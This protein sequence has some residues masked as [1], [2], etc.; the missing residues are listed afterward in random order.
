M[1]FYDAEIDG[2]FDDNYI[3][4]AGGGASVRLNNLLSV[5]D[6]KSSNPK[7]KSLKTSVARHKSQNMQSIH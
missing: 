3:T 6:N 7:F 5:G 1:N 2:E 4:E